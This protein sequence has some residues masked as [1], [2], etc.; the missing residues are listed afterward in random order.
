MCCVDVDTCRV[1]EAGAS[2]AVV[3]PRVFIHAGGFCEALVV[4]DCRRAVCEG[5]PG[6]G[7][8][9]EVVGVDGRTAEGEC[10]SGEFGRRKGDVRGLLNESGEGL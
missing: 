8:S 3:V 2:G 7:F 10:V 6:V 5:V 4:V 1:G 9:G